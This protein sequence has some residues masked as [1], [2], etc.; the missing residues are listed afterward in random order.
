MIQILRTKLFSVS[1]LMTL[2][3][4][5]YL[6]KP[7]PSPKA[8]SENRALVLVLEPVAASQS[9]TNIY[10]A[11]A[12]APLAPTFVTALLLARGSAQ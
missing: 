7:G 9:E 5:N 3:H 2:R 11:G 12:S 6:L 1:Y 10:C 4:A 8:L